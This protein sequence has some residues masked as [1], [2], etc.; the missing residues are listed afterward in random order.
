MLAAKTR[1]NWNVMMAIGTLYALPS[2]AQSVPNP[3]A[4]EE[5]GTVQQVYDGALLPDIQ[6]NTFR[7]IDRLF[8]TRTVK[9]DPN[10]IY[11]LP[12]SEKN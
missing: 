4:K 2:F 11:P 3:H 10:H 12:E 8:A 6:A 7:N 1:I 5:I 9:H